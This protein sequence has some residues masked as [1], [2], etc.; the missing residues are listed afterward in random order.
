M[1]YIKQL[2]SFFEL[3]IVNPLSA[4][5][6]CLYFNLL[7]INN[8]C[9]WLKEF[10]VANSTLMG[11]TGMNISALQRARNDLIQKGYIK[12]QKGRSN[13]AGYYSI[14]DFEQQS[15]QQSEQQN[16]QQNKQQNEQQS[17][18]Q[19]DST[20]NNTTNTLNK[21]NETKQ[22]NNK[23]KNNKKKY[24]EY[25]NVLLDDEQ[26]QKLLNE[27]PNDY[28]DRIQRLDDY[29]QSKGKKYKDYLATIRTWA[30]KEGYK[31]PEKEAEYKEIR[32]DELTE[33][34]YIKLVRGG[35]DV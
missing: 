22:K 7:S 4:N 9:N 6:Q 35:Q 19:N 10:T 2:N 1:N 11:F 12:Y 13:N 26:Y 8:K 15:K 3:L 24:G 30:R 31:K 25:G 34:E 21:L 28:K 23:E 18:Q 32:A 27:F 16:E 33:E 14:V 29:I 5:S 20:T 17:E